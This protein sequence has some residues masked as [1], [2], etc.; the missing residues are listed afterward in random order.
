MPSE[1]P[2]TSGGVGADPSQRLPTAAD[3]LVFE[4]LTIFIAGALLMS[5]LYSGA[6]RRFDQIGVAGHDSF[7][8]VKMAAMLPSLGLVEEFPW[9]RFAY[10][11]RSGHDFVSHH[12]GYHTLLAP[13][14]ALSHWLTG[15]YLAGGRWANGVFLGLTLALF[16]ALLLVGD[17]PFRWLWL[18]LFFLLPEQFFLRHA[19]VRAI[20]PSLALLLLLLILLFRNRPIWVALVV[21]AYN[22]LYLGAVMYTPLVVGLFFVGSLIAPRSEIRVPWLLTGMAALGWL[23][24]A[25]TYPYSRGM[26]EFLILQVFGTGL[27]PDISVGNEWRAY[28]DVWWF[29][30]VHAGALLT[31]FATAIVLRMRLG[32]RLNANEAALLMI[33]LAFFVLT[34]KARRFIEYWPALCLISAA[35]LCAPLLRSAQEYRI[36]ASLSGCGWPWLA[37]AALL[38][39]LAAVA[40]ALVGVAAWRGELQRLTQHWQFLAIVGVLTLPHLLRVWLVTSGRPWRRLLGA[41]G[42]LLIATAAFSGVATFGGEQLAGARKDARCLYDLKSIREMMGF[43]RQRSQ[44]GDVIFTDDWDIFPVFFY[45]NDYNHY[46]VGLDPKFTHE[47]APELW[48]RYVRLSRGQ[49][50]ITVDFKSCDEQG[51]EQSRPVN[52]RLED[53]REHFDARWVITDR[54]HAALAAKLHSARYF[55]ELVFPSTSFEEARQAPYQVFRIRRADETGAGDTVAQFDQDGILYLGYVAP[56]SVEQGW[57]DLRV[58]SSVDGEPIRVGGIQHLRGLGT[59]APSTLRFAVP[60]GYDWFEATVG[61]NSS[62]VKDGSVGIRVLLDGEEAFTSERLSGPVVE[63]ISL[64]LK[65]VREIELRADPTDD[66]MT[67]DHVDWASARFVREP[68]PPAPAAPEPD[69]PQ[70][71]APASSSAPASTSSPRNSAYPWAHPRSAESSPDGRQHRGGRR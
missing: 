37:R 40:T 16:Y 20:T 57:G 35:Y 4:F 45:H 65:G 9:L 62:R 71:D 60:A 61:V 32:P 33:N 26:Y 64:P 13:F 53:L 21:A 69:P 30:G 29:A 14:V 58:D 24:G 68:D 15:D 2:T 52:V 12:Y 6:D 10:F 8:H 27:T 17:V 3:W 43:I 44:P 31:T 25:V 70:D 11:T 46:V 42:V 5:F 48:E 55:A 49:A 47:R 7:Y 51:G 18:T 56:Q 50:P 28:Q 22:H 54:D 36:R 38:V 1:Q 59:H 67:G 34:L 23:V 41:S 63:R 39:G 66:G 19:Y